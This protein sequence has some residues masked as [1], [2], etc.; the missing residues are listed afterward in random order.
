MHLP[1]HALCNTTAE[2]QPQGAKTHTQKQLNELSFLGSYQA[3]TIFEFREED[4]NIDFTDLDPLFYDSGSECLQ[5]VGI[6][7]VLS[8]AYASDSGYET[9]SPRASASSGQPTTATMD[10]HDSSADELYIQYL[11]IPEAPLGKRNRDSFE[12]QL[13]EPSSSRARIDEMALAVEM[14]SVS[15]LMPAVSP[16]LMSSPVV[17]TRPPASLLPHMLSPAVTTAPSMT[18]SIVQGTGDRHDNECSRYNAWLRSMS[19]LT[20]FN[21][22]LELASHGGVH[23]ARKITSAVTSD[24]SSIGVSIAVCLLYADTMEPVVLKS[25][26][27]CCEKITVITK[28]GNTKEGFR[29]FYHNNI[30]FH[31]GSSSKCPLSTEE[32]SPLSTQEYFIVKPRESVARFNVKFS[33]NVTS[34]RHGARN[35]GRQFLWQ[36]TLQ[37]TGISDQPVTATT[38]SHQF[39]YIS[40]PKISEKTIM[41]RTTL[42][43]QETISDNRP[44]DII[45][46]LGDNLHNNQIVAELGNDHVVIAKLERARPSKEAFIGR[47]PS[48]ILPGEYWIRIASTDSSSVLPSQ[49]VPIQIF[50]G[51]ASGL[52]NATSTKC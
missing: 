43:L 16:P 13:E 20:Y 17:D 37:M 46:C 45:T 2:F 6:P 10:V 11:N 41:E 39:R 28:N 21:V 26:G 25:E 8:Y 5:Q 22:D 3:E 34:R 52:A 44:G 31:N 32:Y 23:M 51:I 7:A 9:N 1:V 33:T 35:N 15:P 24:A 4:L 19:R 12:T 18:C 47:L 50:C 48:N 42:Q 36:C 14:P 29:D 49:K 27:Q 30:S 40:R 38:L